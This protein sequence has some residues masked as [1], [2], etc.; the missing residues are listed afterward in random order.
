MQHPET[1]LRSQFFR[2]SKYIAQLFYKTATGN[3]HFNKQTVTLNKKIFGEAILY[4][5]LNNA[6]NNSVLFQKPCR[7]IFEKA[8]LMLLKKYD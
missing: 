7:Q 3:Y 2:L 6:Q 1:T 8:K 4:P 5:T